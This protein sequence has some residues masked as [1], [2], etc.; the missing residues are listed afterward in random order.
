MNDKNLLA[1]CGLYCG[2]CGGYGGGIAGKARELM[3]VL[4]EYRFKKTV[5]H[6]FPEQIKDYDDFYEKLK[7]ISTLVCE[8]ACRMKNVEDTHCEIKKCAIEKD[9]FACY[10]CD[11]YETCEKLATLEELHGDS[12]VKNLTAIKEMGLEKWIESG[13]RLWFGSQE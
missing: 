12:C 1:Y 5:E 13:D 6:H 9:Y 3:D 7:F 11:D 2:D 10:E 8:P 4:K